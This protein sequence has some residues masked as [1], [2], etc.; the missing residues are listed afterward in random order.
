V[1]CSLRVKISTAQTPCSAI[2]Q[3]FGR[4]LWVNP[5]ALRENKGK[6]I[7]LKCPL[8]IAALSTEFLNPEVA[9]VT[10]RFPPIR[11]T[12]RVTVLQLGIGAPA[13]SGAIRGTEARVRL[14]EAF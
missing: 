10:S 12:Y 3:R 1:L 5:V 11:W 4:S 9:T 8:A 7:L 2:F 13:T 6:S 14:P